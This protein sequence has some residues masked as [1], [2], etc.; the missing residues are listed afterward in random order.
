ML[1]L[2]KVCGAKVSSFAQLGLSSEKHGT[3]EK[4]FDAI[5]DASVIGFLMLYFEG[6][7][8]AEY[9]LGQSFKPKINQ[10][11]KKKVKWEVI[12]SWQPYTYGFVWEGQ[13]CALSLL[14]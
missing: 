2:P 9:N 8:F 5:P 11:N 13:K 4:D 6:E 7:V 3:F 10:P 12:K 14:S 1:H